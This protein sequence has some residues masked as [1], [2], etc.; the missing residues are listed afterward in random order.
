MH[1]ARILLQETAAAEGADAADDEYNLSPVDLAM[2]Q[3]A[4][5]HSN[6]LLLLTKRDDTEWYQDRKHADTTNAFL[7]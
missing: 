1:A 2:E 4:Q 7:G 5:V 6:L 3:R